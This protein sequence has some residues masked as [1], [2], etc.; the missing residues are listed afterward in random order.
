MTTALASTTQIKFTALSPMTTQLIRVRTA[1]QQQQGILTVGRTVMTYRGEPKDL[2]L[3]LDYLI[4]SECSGSGPSSKEVRRLREVR[5]ML[6]FAQSAAEAGPLATDE[7]TQL[8]SHV[9]IT[10]GSPAADRDRILDLLD[11]IWEASTSASAEE[12]TTLADASN[13]NV[14]VNYRAWLAEV[15]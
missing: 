8:A 12:L 14:S 1:L 11:R 15:L 9:A 4:A 2:D 7:E 3:L 13:P 5:R 10:T 6:R